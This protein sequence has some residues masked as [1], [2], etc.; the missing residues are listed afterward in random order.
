MLFVLVLSLFWLITCSLYL[1][2]WS[3]GLSFKS[4]GS[5]TLCCVEWIPELIELDVVMLM[6][7]L[8]EYSDN[9]A[10]RSGSLWQYSKDDP[11]VMTWHSF[12]SIR[13]TD[14]YSFKFKSKITNNSNAGM[15]NIEIAVSL[16]HKSYFCI[17]KKYNFKNYTSFCLFTVTLTMTDYQNWDK[18]LMQF[19][20]T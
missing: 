5:L 19:L 2:S 20:I 14:S 9:Y 6:Y 3:E 17:F 11:N 13:A 4:S 12:F 7:I 8:I 16:S 10:R 15:V 1:L 18:F